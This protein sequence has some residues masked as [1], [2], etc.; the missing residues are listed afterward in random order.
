M[1]NAEYTRLNDLDAITWL[2][3]PEF[4]EQLGTSPANVRGALKDRRIVARRESHRVGPQIPREFLVPAHLA[5]AAAPKPA[6][7]D[8]GGKLVI[9]PSLQGT[10]IVL[11]DQGLN[12]EDIL[13]WLF[14]HHS[15]LQATPLEVLRQGNK[16]AV[17]RVALVVG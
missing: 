9:L 3:V 17:R 1:S 11:S 12:D 8:G 5:N 10:I 6:P 14:S 15:E 4:A 7:A 16:S 2:S 13:V